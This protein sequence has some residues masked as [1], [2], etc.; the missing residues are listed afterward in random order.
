MVTPDALDGHVRSGEIE[1]LSAPLQLAAVD[2]AA[3]FAP[4][5]W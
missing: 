5:A 3:I 4:S 2:D 1:P